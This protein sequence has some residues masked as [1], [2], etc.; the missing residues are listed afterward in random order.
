[1]NG[2]LTLG[3]LLACV[4]ASQAPAYVK[5]QSFSG[6]GGMNEALLSWTTIAESDNLGFNVHR[7]LFQ[8]GPF[9]QVN[10]QMIPGA[11]TSTVPNDYSFTDTGFGRGTAFYYK[12]EDVDASGAS[13]FHGP[14]EVEVTESR[15]PNSSSPQRLRLGSIRPSP[16]ANDVVVECVGVSTAALRLVTPTGKLSWQTLVRSEGKTL[17]TIPL[18]ACPPGVYFVMLQAADG[19][20]SRPL[21]VAR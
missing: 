14:I 15:D 17:V 16:A 20:D 21:V 2:R 8:E 5:L 10:A 3:I 1:M 4:L 6:Q 13:T 18:A 19:G 12:L 11:G 7:S 9:Q